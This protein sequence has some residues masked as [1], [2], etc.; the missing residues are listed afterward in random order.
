MGSDSFK[1]TK[2]NG[3]HQRPV[4][5]SQARQ[6]VGERSWDKSLTDG[7]VCVAI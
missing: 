4:R 3:S 7:V 2:E 1:G 6:L 5:G